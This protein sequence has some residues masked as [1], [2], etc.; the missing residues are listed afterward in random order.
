[1]S[2]LH[3][4]FLTLSFVLL[5][6]C[7]ETKIDSRAVYM[8]L[9]TSGT[10]TQQFE[11]A[12]GI[13]KYLLA[14]LSTG[15]ALALA[16]IDSGSFSE[17]DII[18]KI[19]FDLRPS[20]ANAQKRAFYTAVNEYAKDIKNSSYTDIT[21]GLLQAIEYLNETA[22]TDKTILIFSDLKEEVK[23]GHVRDFPIQFNG[24]RVVALNVTKLKSDNVDPREYAGRIEAWKKRVEDGGGSWQ[25]MNDFDHLDD[26]LK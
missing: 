3:Y 9:D 14:K 20:K 13:I 18:A 17:K 25:V 8:L 7:T 4:A 22:A 23:E 12:N 26:L 21:G 15:D 10:Y 11:K 19:T 24:I 6:A 1:M 2:R 5:S 16:R